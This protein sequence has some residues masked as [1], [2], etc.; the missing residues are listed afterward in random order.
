M[1]LLV[2]N[3]GFKLAFIA[4]CREAQE[5]GTEKTI[6]ISAGDLHFPFL[7]LENEEDKAERL[8]AEWAIMG[9]KICD[10][11]VSRGKVVVFSLNCQAKALRFDHWFLL[12]NFTT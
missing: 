12:T 11:L 6:I 7:A 9:T 8:L 5:C 10:L 2:M 3:D 1:G 4:L